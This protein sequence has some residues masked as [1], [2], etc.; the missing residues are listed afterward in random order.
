MGDLDDKSKI[1]I[2]WVAV[3]LVSVVG[4][5]VRGAFWTANVDNRLANLEQSIMR[6]EQALGTNRPGPVKD[7]ASAYLIR[8]AAAAEH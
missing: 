7:S 3:I 2:W 4:A 6:I 8:P 1:P 5:S